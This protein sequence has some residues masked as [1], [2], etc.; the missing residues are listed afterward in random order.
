MESHDNTYINFSKWAL[1]LAP[2]MKKTDR[3][4]R[5][6]AKLISPNI[7][8]FTE[9]IPIQTII[10]GNRE[11]HLG[12]S[13]EEKPLALQL[14]TGSPA[15]IRQTRKIP[16]ILDFDE[17]NL[18]CGCPSPT[19]Q[20]GNF[21]VKLMLDPEAT[22]E[23]VTTLRQQIPRHIPISIKIRLGVDSLYSYAYLSDYVGM[24]VQSGASIIFVHARK[25]LLNINPK[26]NREVP[27]LN[28]D[29]VYRLKNDF[30]D[31]QIVINGGITHARES[32][33]H[34]SK[35]D[36]IM[37]G[38]IAYQNPMALSD[39]ENKIF[40][41][42]ISPKLRL[43]V[44]EKYLGYAENQMNLGQKQQKLVLNL[45][46]IFSGQKRAKEWRVLLNKQSKAKRISLEQI[47][48][49]ADEIQMTNN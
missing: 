44:V 17:I 47:C 4:F 38:R 29:W 43:N 13:T 26:K 37:L 25:A 19:V 18:N 28:Y 41:K 16:E 15:D 31:T 30:K 48:N 49:K 24:A 32:D 34:L 27:N 40:K 35:V 42:K 23:C 7:R 36:G 45:L 1:C 39:F 11:R 14:G 21:G 12:F 33:I 9:M 8:L 46:N 6:L 5:F 20:S 22:R 10:N 3:H 2:M